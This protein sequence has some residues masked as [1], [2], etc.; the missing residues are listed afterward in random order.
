MPI[1]KPY[2]LASSE[3]QHGIPSVLEIAGR[4]VGGTHFALMAGPCTV[5]SRE[6]TLSAA[7]AVN[8]AAA[9]MF[10]GGAFKPRS[11]PYSFRGLARHGLVLLASKR[12]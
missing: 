4:R 3:L 11:S 10:R 12:R 7:R 1:L 9:T 6:Q 8:D 2:K 5:E